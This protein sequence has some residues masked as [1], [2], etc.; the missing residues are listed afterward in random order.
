[1]Q[2]TKIALISAATLLVAGCGGHKTNGNSAGNTANSGP[3]KPHGPGSGQTVDLVWNNGNGTWKVKLNGGPE[4][5]PKTAKTTLD[6]NVGPT[7]FTVNIGGNATFADEG[8]LD[9]WEGQNEKANPKPG[10]NSTQILGPV[11]TKNG[12]TLVFYDLNYGSG[13]RL[14]YQ[15]NFKGTVPPVDPIIDNGGGTW[16]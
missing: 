8:A 15:L 16:N 12:K 4:Q 7:M 13:V 14:N 6:A 2:I 3:I 9:V 11:V 10:I 1:M 5:D